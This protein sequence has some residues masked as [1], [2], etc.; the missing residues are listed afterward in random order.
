[1]SKYTPALEHAKVAIELGPMVWHGRYKG[2]R[3][4][5]VAAGGRMFTSTTVNELVKGGYAVAVGRGVVSCLMMREAAANHR[6]YR[7]QVQTDADPAPAG[8]GMLATQKPIV[9]Q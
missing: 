7:P 5:F 6:S 8:I 1:M 2:G 9:P 4:Q 3:S